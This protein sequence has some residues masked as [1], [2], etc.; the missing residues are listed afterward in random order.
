MTLFVHLLGQAQISRD[1]E[2]IDIPGHRPLALLAYLLVTREAHSRQHLVDLL[3]EGPDDPRAALRWTLYKL[4]EAI[5]PECL[6]ADRQEIA[7]NFES[8]YWLDVTAF[9]AGQLDLYRGDFLEGLG[10]RDAYRFEDWLFFERERLRSTYQAALAQRLEDYQSGGDDE[11][12]VETAHQLLRLDNLCEEGYRALMRAYARQGKREVALAQYDQ[13]CRLLAEELGIEPAQE[14]ISLFEQIQAGTLAAAIPA[15][16]RLPEA[17]PRLPAFLAEAAAPVVSEH[18]LFVARER[19][20]ARLA[21]HLTAALEGQGRV[22]FVTGEAGRGKTALLTE[23]AHRA[24]EAHAGLIVARG[25]CNAYSGAGDP[26]LPFRDVLGMLSG[27]VESRWA[28]GTITQEH[29]RR[30]WALMPYTL[31]ALVDDGPDLIDVLVPGSGLVTRIAASAPGM[32]SWQKRLKELTQRAKAERGNLQQHQLFEQYTQVLHTLAARRPLLVLLDDLQWADTTSINLLFHMGRRLAG[33][34]IL[35]VGAYRASEVAY[36]RPSIATQTPQPHPLK[37]VVNEFKRHFGDIEIDLGQIPPAESRAF[38]DTLLDSE[39]NRLDEAFRAALF[40]QTQGHPLFTIEMLRD[41]Q[42]RGDLVQDDEGCRIEVPPLDWDALPARVEAVIE[43][44]LGRL[45]AALRDILSVASVEGETF[46]AQIVARL[47]DLSERQLLHRLSQELQQR[48][49]LVRD[50][51]EVTVGNKRLSRY[52]FGH[53]LVQQYLYDRLSPGERRLLHNE[54][55]VILEELYAGHTDEITVQLARHYAEAGQGEKAIPYLSRAGDQARLAYAHEEAIDFY[56]RAL[57]F[58]KEQ[59]DYE[60]AAR[61]WMKLGLTYHNAFNFEQARQAYEEGFALWQQ[62]GQT[63]PDAPPPLAAH[64]LR[65]DR[66]PPPATLD[67]TTTEDIFSSAVIAQLFSGL[68]EQTAEL[69]IVPDV[70]RRWEVLESGCKYVF[71]LRDDVRWTDGTPVTA[72][73]FVYAWKRMLGPATRSSEASRMY[74]IKGARAFH[75]GKMLDSDKLGVQ[76]LDEVTLVVELESPTSYFLHLLARMYPVPRRVLEIHGKAWTDVNNIV[77]NGPFKL[78]AWQPEESLVLI[79]NPAY[80]GHF[81]GN[82][83][84]MELCLLREW[85]DRLEMYENDKLDVLSFYRLPPSERDRIRQRYAGEYVSVPELATYY[86]AFDTSRPPFNDLRVRRA[87][88][89]ATDKEMLANVAW[90]GEA[91]PATGGLVPPGVPGYSAGIGLP[92][93]LDQA[94]QLLAAAGYLDGD[95]FPTVEA[96]VPHP[97][98]PQSEY[99]QANWRENLGIEIHW[100]ALEWN[101]FLQRLQI[102]PPNMSFSGWGAGYPDPDSFLRVISL[103]RLTCWQNETYERLVKEARRITGQ[104]RR[105][106]M[107]RQ[108]DKILVEEAPVLLLV[109]PRE[110]SLVKPW[111]K[112]YP[113]SPLVIEFWFGK[114]VIIEPH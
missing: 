52:Q 37:P 33:G 81:T 21:E 44:R 98:V 111:V 47:Q 96:L 99:L 107:Y 28:A 31:Q 59:A 69:E 80:H 77:T 3:C 102:A 72:E 62:A 106:E 14:T 1:G 88:V 93:N 70:A 73:D 85:S 29:A 57:T 16:V 18:T 7:F 30:L 27:D 24:Q 103:G 114:D 86:I 34:R 79:R 109:Y 23:F 100:H 55:A 108:A 26:Y 5:G 53:V 82:V 51:G 64:T 4:R 10:V 35:I 60:S 6:L 68:V 19:E 40:R 63:Q 61:T 90:R 75:Q 56:Q 36:G 54:I 42:E 97:L 43:Q 65:M 11:A 41:M 67:P 91:T 25:N 46:T 105:M 110:G 94:R 12:V 83:K 15:P 38:V 76:A 17:P 45:D 20:L 104:K 32:A 58:L 101:E 92:Y 22:V 8:D 50:Q 113:T 2:P 74:D 48:H 89:L 9:E 84:R 49:R 95:G 87:F 112:K 13:C 78:E 66:F 39:P 71:H